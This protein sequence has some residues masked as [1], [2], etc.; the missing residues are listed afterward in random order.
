MESLLIS[1]YIAI[2]KTIEAHSHAYCYISTGLV[3]YNLHEDVSLMCSIRGQ[4][5]DQHKSF[6]Q[7]PVY[8]QCPKFMSVRPSESASP[9]AKLAS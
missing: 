5:Y 8:F 4:F 1:I 7:V 9:S 6:R 2:V 3:R